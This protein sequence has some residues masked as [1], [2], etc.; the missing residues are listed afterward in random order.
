MSWLTEWKAISECIQGTLEAGE[1]YIRVCNLR[2]D[3]PAGVAG[4]YLIPRAK[5]I[6]QSIQEFRNKHKSSLPPSAASCLDNFIS[7]SP[8]FL[9]QKGFFGVQATLSPLS[10]F[11]A[12][13]TYKISDSS[14]LIRRISE[15]A[16]IHLNRTIAIN[17]NIKE[18]WNN[19]FTKHETRCEK[20][21]AIHLLGHGIWSFKVNA[22]GGR[23]DLVYEEPLSNLNEV[24]KSA[25]GLVLTEWKLIKNPIDLNKKIDEAYKQA[26][27]YSSGVL[28]GIELE[29]Y[30]YLVMVS[31]KELD[32]PQDRIEGD[33]VYRHVN[34]PVNPD[35]PSKIGKKGKQLNKS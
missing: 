10:A 14:I 28:A 2:S 4:K 13:F 23:T 1:F 24:E 8:N 5:E 3:D 25:E 15:R 16:F 35:V 33:L 12:E 6:F 22:E 18:D 29:K 32:M 20:L 31:E 7:M 11:R 21:G 34:I 27:K 26:S 30:R 9:N 17:S 19:A